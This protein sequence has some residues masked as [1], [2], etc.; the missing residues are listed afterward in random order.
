MILITGIT[1]KTGGGL[2][3][4]MVE[5]GYKDTIRAVVRET[6]NLS[7]LKSSGLS[8][9]VCYGD[10]SDEEFISRAAE[11]CETV[12]HLASKGHIDRIAKAVANTSSVRHCYFVSSTSIYSEYRAASDKLI[13]AEKEMKL[14]FQN[15]D[16]SIAY[17]IIRPT[18]IFGS[19]NDKNIST[20]MK[21]L[22]KYPV[23]PI[24]N[25]GEALLQPVEKRDLGKGIFQLLN[26][27]DEVKNQ[28]YIISG[29]RP[30]SLKYCLQSISD[31]I[32]KKT[33]FINI[34]MPIAKAAVYTVWGLSMKKVDYIEKLARLTEDRSFDHKE[35]TE[36]FGY[37][38][39]S[40]EFWLQDLAKDYLDNKMRWEK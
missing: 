16:E 28:E 5:N 9:E 38:P 37:T 7:K 3:D 31:S 19:I 8:Y 23:F 17:T 18:M 22:D 4:A 30:I 14:L 39:Q 15:N 40:F 2:I 13:A 33:L 32:G 27:P 12:C 24:V 36:Q 6:S 10:I 20:F 34:P 1:G 35:M 11:G 26:H 29:D 25:N 21:W